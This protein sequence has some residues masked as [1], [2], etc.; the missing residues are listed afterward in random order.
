MLVL[1]IQIIYT[2]IART[3]SSL[4]PIIIY[5]LKLG[6]YCL[7][8]LKNNLLDDLVINANRLGLKKLIQI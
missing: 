7:C 5:P 2:T 1:H 6:S 8:V 3:E 4:Y